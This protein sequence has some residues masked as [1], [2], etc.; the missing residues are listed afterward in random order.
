MFFKVGA[1]VRG[2][3][4]MHLLVFV[5]LNSLVLANEID[6]TSQVG[7]VWGGVRLY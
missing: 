7:W 5:A 4:A 1:L 2:H 3:A 6:A